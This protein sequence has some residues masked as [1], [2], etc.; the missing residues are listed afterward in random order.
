MTP[1]TF[2]EQVR[3]KRIEKGLTQKQLATISGI[4]QPTISKLEKGKD[5][6]SAAIDKILEALDIEDLPLSYPRRFI[7]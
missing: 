2:G 6:G 4:H 1:K 5:V 7:K 3:I